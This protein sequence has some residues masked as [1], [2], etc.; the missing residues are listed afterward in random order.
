MKYSEEIEND[1]T[2]KTR[3]LIR[4]LPE[5]C[6]EY[7]I[8]INETAAPRTKLA[9]CYDLRVFFNYLITEQDRFAY[10]KDI[11][12]FTL[13]DL[14]KV[15][16]TILR[17]F[18]E[19]LSFYYP[20]DD[21]ECMNE[22]INK[23]KGKARK[24]SAVRK[25][26]RYFY[27]EEK[28]SANP[29]ELVETPK[30]HNKEIIRLEVDEIAKLLDE[31]ESGDKL[32]KSQQ[33]YHKHTQKRDLA[34]ITLLLGTGMRVSECVGLDIDDIDFEINGAKIIRK[35]GNEAVVYF[36]DEVERALRDYIQLRKEMKPA[37]G[38][39]NALFLSLQNKRIGVRAVQL[40][41]KKYSQTVTTMK[42]IT[43]HKLRSTYG[44]QL[45]S[46]TGDI[47]LVASVLGHKDVNTTKTHYAALDD[48]K[49]RKA[50][51]VVKLRETE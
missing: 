8:A 35:G 7:F 44:T 28:I 10:I 31:V 36:G 11:R 9:Y 33:S 46:E 13:K 18:L 2:V 48:L 39:E 25:L 5:F 47:Y 23:E 37:K 19:Y 4:E 16:A 1:M 42:N 21:E 29:G 45:Y 51:N 34:I 26:L 38:N 14:E 27:R 50:A 6:H 20:V 15:S 40:L 24:L 22:H 43:P 49:R 17:E 30:I 41:V 32:T 3:K 12:D